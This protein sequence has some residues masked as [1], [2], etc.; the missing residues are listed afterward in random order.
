[1]PPGAWR[2]LLDGESR[3]R[4]LEIIDA[5][6]RAT[7]TIE[8]PTNVASISLV[9][10][11]TGVGVFHHH[12]GHPSPALEVVSDAISEI[13]LNGSLWRGFTGVAWLVEHAAQSAAEDATD[14]ANEAIDE[15]LLEFLAGESPG[16]DLLDG[17]TGIGVYA[18]E[19]LPRPGAVTML[20]MVVAK[21]RASVVSRD[22]GLT[23]FVR[24]EMLP[25]QIRALHPKGMVQLG[26]AH[27]IN[28]VIGFLGHTCRAGVAFDAARALL[29]DVVP[30]M[31]AQALP[32]PSPSRFPFQ[33][34]EGE[35]SRPAH[36]AWCMG[37]PGIAITL[38]AAARGIDEPSWEAAAIEIACKAAR[39][40][41]EDAGV[42][43]A[44]LCHG[45]A[46][47]GHL[48]NRMHQA[49]HNETL[50]IAARVWLERTIAMRQPTRAVAGF[51]VHDPDHGDP[52]VA[53]PGLLY[54]AAGVGLALAAAVSEIEPT[55]DRLFLMNVA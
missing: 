43:D 38:L 47:L 54:G 8:P 36:A 18:L 45:A 29:L 19:R 37:D 6:T 11:L 23:W 46:G 22:G 2:S 35:P 32:E 33:I 51:P 9:G 48:F 44:G 17:L 27:G 52:W 39:R 49:T 41:V 25:P 14:D 4:A 40:S 31:L 28:G 42:R 26:V 24:P 21:L 30:W 1:M 53:D 10:G 16:F 20:E 50:G 15:A 5:I 34:E 13:P 55:W 12:V 3:D 7:S